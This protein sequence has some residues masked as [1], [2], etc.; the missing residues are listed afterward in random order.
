MAFIN[1]L[2]EREA[3]SQTSENYKSMIIEYM[4][5]R[6]YH[7]I[8]DSSTDA[9][10]PDLVFKRP[11]VDGDR[12]TIVE[13]KFTDLSLSDKNFL[14][15][16]GRHFI[17]Y[18]KRQPQNKFFLYIFVRRC[19][20]VNNWKKVFEE[21]KLFDSDIKQLMK[22]VEKV[23]HEEYKKEF[24]RYNHDDFLT[25][26]SDCTIIQADYQGLL[27]KVDELRKSKK[28]D[29]NASYLKDESEVSKKPEKLIGNFLKVSKMPENIW[30]ADSKK[31]RDIKEFWSDNHQKILYPYG[32][33]IYSVSS[34]SE[35]KI[36]KYVKKGT[37]KEVRFEDWK[38]SEEIKQKILAQLIKKFI[39]SRG[40]RI[41]CRYDNKLS[42]LFFEHKSLKENLKKLGGRKVS[43]VFRGREGNVNFVEHNG[44]EFRV[45]N[46]DGK[47]YVFL[48]PIRLFTED[49]KEIIRGTSA[50]ALHYKF[51]PKYAFNNTEKSKFN[52]WFKLLG[53]NSPLLVHDNL[54][55]MS[56]P[57]SVKIPVRSFGGQKYDGVLQQ[58]SLLQFLE[59]ED[60]GDEL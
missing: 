28:F 40:A 38:D 31:I 54:F 29:L 53:L 26:I 39:I 57:V 45:Y 3:L 50:K 60:E 1:L 2:G 14:E 18:M 30:I 21:S 17:M 25:F 52:Y 44:L 10:L 32:D 41:G 55:F 22:R 20:A 4:K 48:N 42:C 8:K 35:G 37:T 6:S 56:E 9:N 12:E 24:E 43:K 7:L 23:I 11:L 15:E 58:Y 19:K 34:M 59:M 16:L 13:S 46:L 36:T 27:M 33:K 47:F 49:G 5:T 51:P